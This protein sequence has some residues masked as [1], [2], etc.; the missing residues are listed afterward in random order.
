MIKIMSEA[1]E[2]NERFTTI[3][4]MSPLQ[5]GVNVDT[6]E[7]VMRTASSHNF[8]VLNLSNSGEYECWT[9][10]HCPIEVR[11]LNAD[12]SITIKLFNGVK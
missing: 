2:K 3:G 1:K 7:Y 8:E 9:S 4:L 6:G 10:E 11:L 5:V 12:E